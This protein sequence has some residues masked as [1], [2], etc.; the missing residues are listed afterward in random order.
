M[1]K[2]AS[3]IRDLWVAALDA[4][5]MARNAWERAARQ[6]RSPGI[7]VSDM[8]GE[9]S[10]HW[11]TQHQCRFNNQLDGFQVGQ[12]LALRQRLPRADGAA[13]LGVGTK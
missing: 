5:G 11:L 9:T 1:V 12:T 4:A 10:D 3:G 6:G 2:T 8:A 13:A 7:V